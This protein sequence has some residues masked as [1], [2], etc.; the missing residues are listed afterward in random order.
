MPPDVEDCALVAEVL[1]IRKKRGSV[2]GVEKDKALSG[3]PPTPP[4][5]PLSFPLG[6]EFQRP[7]DVR[8]TAEDVRFRVGVEG[9]MAGR[10]QR[11]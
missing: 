2:A 5:Q 11:G 6:Q 8:D 7:I 4:A 9:A 3:T 1:G 10:R